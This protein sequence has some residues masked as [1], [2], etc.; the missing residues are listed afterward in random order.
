MRTMPLLNELQFQERNPVAEPLFVDQSG[1]ILRFCLQPNQSITEHRVPHSP[2]YVVVLRGQGVFAGDDG[3]ETQLGPNSLIVFDPD[4]KHTVRA[5]AEELVFVGF[6]Q[7]APYV[8][9]GKVGGKLGS[10]DE[11]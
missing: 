2:F 11:S 7:G 3:K 10:G 5:L 9:E 8:R 4:E 6:L 1:R